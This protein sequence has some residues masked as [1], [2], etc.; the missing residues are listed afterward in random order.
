M[1]S[2][3]LLNKILTNFGSYMTSNATT[4]QKLLTNSLVN[5]YSQSVSGCIFFE[6]FLEDL[7]IGFVSNQITDN[8]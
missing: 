8:Y 6:L 3:A 4:C 1:H 7:K 2:F 5:M